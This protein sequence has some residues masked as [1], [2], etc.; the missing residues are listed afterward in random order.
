M[1]TGTYTCEAENTY[2]F[3]KKTVDIE[4]FGKLSENLITWFIFI[5]HNICRNI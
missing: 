3:D 5:K 4:V 2:G 1:D